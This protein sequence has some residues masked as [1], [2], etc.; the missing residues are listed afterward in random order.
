MGD[1]PAVMRRRGRSAVMVAA[2]ILVIGLAMCAVTARLFIWPRQDT[3]AHADAIVM[4]D[5]SGNRLPTAERLARLHHAP[6][7]VV[8]LG[9]PLSGR[10][11]SCPRALPGSTVI[12]FH[13]DPPTTRG[14]AELIGRLASSHHWRSVIMVASTPQLTPARI[15]LARCYGGAIYPVGASLPVP[16]WPFA[17]AYEWGATLNAE[18][19][20]RS[21]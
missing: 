6:V 20:Q 11:G 15:W 14:E 7:L 4:L 13:P 8:S 10:E 17:I 9:A 2:A 16:M 19:V 21:C 3:A 1:G 12:C 18:L 5:G